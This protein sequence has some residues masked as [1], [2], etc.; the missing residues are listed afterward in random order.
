MSRRS[1]QG[2]EKVQLMWDIAE[3]RGF[4]FHLVVG[5][6]DLDA[7]HNKEQ[8]TWEVKTDGRPFI[9]VVSLELIPEGRVGVD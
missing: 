5:E 4:F 9:R 2:S 8:R 3:S 6:N 7:P 1:K